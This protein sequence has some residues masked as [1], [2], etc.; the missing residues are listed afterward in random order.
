M[1]AETRH[2]LKTNE[3]GDLL[4]QVA[5]LRDRRVVYAAVAV[6][7]ALL[8]YVSYR[9]WSWRAAASV[10]AGW[11]AL[12]AVESIDPSLGEAPLD[13][14]RAVVAEASDPTLQAMARLRLA[15]ALHARA[16][17]GDSSRLTEAQQQL[18]AILAGSTPPMLKAAAIYQLGGLYESRRQFDQARLAYQQLQQDTS[19]A[20]S[21][22]VKLAEIRLSTLDELP[23]KIELLPGLPPPPPVA[24]APA[25]AEAQTVPPPGGAG[26]DQP[27]AQ[28]LPQ[29]QPATSQP[30]GDR[31]PDLP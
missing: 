27:S 10:N 23:E 12:Q 14:L 1:D 19:L 31:P 6:G 16:V 26:G 7:L 11:A 30:E 25:E 20:G 13:R 8:A 22:F 17:A 3:L 29:S 18:E 28:T 15:D 21:P 24:S 2:Q 4:E 5:N 9:V